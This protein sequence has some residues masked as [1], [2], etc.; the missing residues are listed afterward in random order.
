MKRSSKICISWPLGSYENY[1]ELPNKKRLLIL[2]LINYVPIRNPYLYNI[3]VPML[4]S[5]R[6]S[7][8]ATKISRCLNIAAD[9]VATIIK[10]AAVSALAM[11]MRAL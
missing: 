2:Q 9:E 6:F 3:R 8:R 1:N 4:V 5:A 10:L 7:R 11:S